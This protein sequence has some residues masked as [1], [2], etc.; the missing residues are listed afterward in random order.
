MTGLLIGTAGTPHSAQLKSTIG[1][2]ERVAEL[3][4]ACMELEFVRS[5]SMGEVTA[6]KVAEAAARTGIR[7]TAH[8]PYYINLNAREPEKI[9]ASQERL[10][11]T[12]RVGA[13]CGAVS[14][15]F[16]AAFYMGDSPEQTYQAVKK[17]LAEVLEELDAEGNHIW[18]RP[19]LMGKASQFGELEELLNLSVDLERVAPCIDFAHCHARTGANNSYNEFSASLSRIEERLGRAALDDMHIHIAGILYG[20]KGERKHLDL[21]ESD[22][23][24]AALM[25]ALRDYN[26]RGVLICESPNLEDDALLLQETYRHLQGDT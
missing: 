4:L 25:K 9:R 6:R 13:M 20:A 11:K 22:M 1:G 14:V 10:L 7:L 17:N 2:I 24:Y 23:E 21:K 26:V 16:H 8:A 18:I 5:V 12:A 3:G 19:E 15:A